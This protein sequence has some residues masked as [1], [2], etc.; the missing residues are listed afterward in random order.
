M[1]HQRIAIKL[2]KAAER[3]IKRGHP[4]VF[5]ESIIKQ[6]KEGQSGDIAVIFGQASNTFIALGLY[7]PD[8]FIR[9]KVLTLKNGVQI[10]FDWFQGTI[11]S[12][13]IKREPLLRLTNAYR[14]IN[15]ENDG[16]PGFICDRYVDVFVIKIYSEI[17][18]S[19]F[20]DISN[21]LIEEF[22]PKAIILRYSRKLAGEKKKKEPTIIYGKLVDSD[23]HFTE[24][25]IKLS[26]N[27]IK[28]HKTGFFLDHRQNRILTQKLSKGR[29]VLDVFS[30]AG[31]F[32]CHALK[33]N[34]KEVTS[35]D[36]SAQALEQ[37]KRNVRLNFQDVKHICIAGDAFEI[38]KNLKDSRT[39]YDL[40]IIDPP[41]FTSSIKQ[42]DIALKKY[43]TLTKLG[44]Q[45][46][47]KSGILMMASCSSRVDKQDFFDSVEQVVKSS[48]RPYK[49]LHKTSH[50]I[51]H[52]IRLKE[53]EY[54]KCGWYQFE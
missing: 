22:K 34:A 2:T 14:L 43:K 16:M 45:L 8:S 10:N 3:K 26:A 25:N 11:L 47:D 27:L 5:D 53:A 4:W 7:D 13:F 50:D 40:I 19:H 1:G 44:V 36:I 29:R 32:T 38:L 6:N 9:V 21:V 15:G 41:S 31:G 18:T 46:L 12:A 23:I 20:E 33:G 30:Y 17:W 28:G 52:P 39:Q 51:D 54:L 37:A 24:K 42:K 49:C 35:V 48:G